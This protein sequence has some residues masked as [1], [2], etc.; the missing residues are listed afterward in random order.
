MMFVFKRESLFQTNNL[1][2]DH[3]NVRV[4]IGNSLCVPFSWY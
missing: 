3:K 4:A 2:S 1:L